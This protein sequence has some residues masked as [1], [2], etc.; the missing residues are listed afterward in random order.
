MKK[1]K[2]A[3]AI[4]LIL[5]LCASV[6]A[7]CGG[8]DQTGKYA[9]AEISNEEGTM[10]KLEDFKKQMKDLYESMGMEFNEAEL[11][12]SGDSYLELLKDN[13]FK[14][15]VFGE[16]GEGTYKI[17]GKNITLT[18]DGESITGT[19]DGKKITIEE[20]EGKLVFVKK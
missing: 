15:L 12:L 7:A 20:N 4:F 13:K 6:L 17:D 8:G 1:M 16:G 5:I 19:I 3:V 18:Y 2:Q 9:L 10:I 11:G 14:M